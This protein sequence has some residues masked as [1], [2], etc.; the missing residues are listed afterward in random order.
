MQFSTSVLFFLTTLSSITQLASGQGT[1]DCEI[2]PAI[3]TNFSW[4]N[5]THNCGCD[6]GGCLPTGLHGGPGCGP[7][8][9][10]RVTFYQSSPTYN[11]TLICGASD[12]G[13]VPARAIPGGPFNCRSLGRRFSFTVNGTEGTLSYVEPNFAWYV[14]ALEIAFVIFH[15]LR[16]I[17]VIVFS[18]T[19][20]AQVT[21]TGSFAMGCEYDSY[22]NATC[23]QRESTVQLEPTEVVG[24]L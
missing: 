23:V 24:I 12:P 2:L 15:G 17:V 1:D 22:R 14:L 20:R 5:S 8:D 19:G 13:S 18:P 10:V 9:T 11:D 4:H 21:Y 3:I 7:P 16:L 6:D